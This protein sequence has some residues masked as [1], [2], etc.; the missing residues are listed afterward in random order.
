MKE[1]KRLSPLKSSLLP[2][3]LVFAFVLM[4]LIQVH[5][6]A[7]AQ[8]EPR[9]FNLKMGYAMPIDGFAKGFDE[10]GAFADPG[11]SFSVGY[12]QLFAKEFKWGVSYFLS[13]NPV[14]RDEIDALIPPLSGIN[15]STGY[16]ISHSF[17]L[18]ADWMPVNNEHFEVS[19]GPQL[20]LTLATSPEL[21][22]S[23]GPLSVRIPTETGAGF[24]YGAHAR[25]VYWTQ[26]HIGFSIGVTYLTAKPEPFNLRSPSLSVLGISIPSQEFRVDTRLSLISA[27]AGFVYR[28]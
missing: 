19:F 7:S 26:G 28:F 2:Q 5:H 12:R 17:L 25:A 14:Q 13:R 10:G 27:Q 16:W 23:L 6:Q 18:S 15:I 3:H 24:V 11:L 9:E 4:F 1:T 20:G 22:G 21:E 8:V